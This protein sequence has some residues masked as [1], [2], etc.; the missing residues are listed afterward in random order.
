MRVAGIPLVVLKNPRFKGTVL[1]LNAASGFTDITG[2][3]T[4]TKNYANN[5]FYL[6][7]ATMTK[8]TKPNY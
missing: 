2:R 7:R 8:Y 3:H 4:F 6:L 1:E 5:G